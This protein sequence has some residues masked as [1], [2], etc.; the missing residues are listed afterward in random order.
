MKIAHC[1]NVAP[2]RCGL[3]GTCR[4]LVRAEISEGIEAG[5]VNV[6][7]SDKEPVI[8]GR[9]EGYPKVKDPEIKTKDIDWA[10]RAD[11]YMRHSYIPMEF[12]NSGKPLLLALHGR[13]ES[14]FRLEQMHHQLIMTTIKKR[15]EDKRYKAFVCFWKEYMYPW[16]TTVP[17]EKL[18]YVPAPVDLDFYN[19]NGPKKDWGELNGNPNILIADIW[20]EDIIPLNMIYAASLFQQKY[21][22]TAKLHVIMQPKNLKILQGT[23]EGIKKSGGLGLIHPMTTKITEFYRATDI[24]ITPHVIATRTVREPLA[25]GVPVVAGQGNKYTPYTANNQNI[26]EFAAAIN[27]C[28]ND[29]R[30]NPE[31]LKAFAR[32]TAELAF[33]LKNTGQAMKRV[34]EKIL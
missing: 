6:S 19:P 20:R 22:K 11:C 12:Q 31:G 23:F 2:N 27:K 14:S 33:N 10:R 9:L 15:A 18:F 16:S 1:V 5:I 26:E 28:W 17:K 8:N 13:P 25:C 7:V 4:D 32:G 30:E 3:Y 29:Y 24:Y 34:L 21:C